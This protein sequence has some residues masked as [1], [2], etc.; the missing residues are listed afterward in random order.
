MIP[1]EPTPNRFEL[2]DAAVKKLR[3]Q[4]LDPEAAQLRHRRQADLPHWYGGGVL[5]T[6]DFA[7]DFD[8]RKLV[9]RTRQAAAL[10]WL[11]FELQD[12][13]SD[14]LC[15]DNKFGFF[16]SLARAALDHLSAHQ[17]EAD[18]PRPLLSAVLDT[19]ARLSREVSLRG[20]LAL[21]SPA[22]LHLEDA[23]GRQVRID[24]FTGK[25]TF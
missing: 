7:S 1:A 25:E 10:T 8:T 18:D 6:D 13:F 16:G 2:L 19:A 3:Q 9:V 22:V 5:V 23:E 14:W 11:I 20:D 21:D 12:A 4:I 24:L 15:F 17:P